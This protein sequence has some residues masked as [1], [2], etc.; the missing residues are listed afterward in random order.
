MVRKHRSRPRWRPLEHVGK[1]RGRIDER[2]QAVGPEHFG[3]VCI[4]PHKGSSVWMLADFYGKVLIEPTPV[5]HRQAELRAAMEQLR[6]TCIDRGIKDT[7]V[8]AERTGQYHLPVRRAFEAGGHEVRIIHPYAT[9]QYRQAADPGDKTDATDLA[10]MHR[11]AVNGFGLTEQSLPTVYRHLQL[12]IRHRRDWVY[13]T[14]ALRTQIREHLGVAMPGY[15]DLNDKFFESDTMLTLARRFDSADAILRAGVDG[16]ADALREAKVQCQRRTLERIV[17]WAGNA[18]PADPDPLLQQQI[19]TA[20]DDD[21]AAKTLQI[22]RL[23]GQ[24]ASL[25]VQTPYLLLLAIPGINVVSAADL[26][27]E[28][29]PIGH[30]ANAN[31]I[32]GRAGL[33]PA[34]AQSNFTDHPDGALR[35]QSNRRLRAVLTQ[36]ADNLV[37]C[38]QHFRSKA[39]AWQIADKDVRAI[40]VRVAKS[41]SRLAYAIVAGGT[42]FRHPAL[43]QRHYVLDKLLAFYQEHDTPM[44][45]RREDLLAAVRWIPEAERDAEAEPLNEQLQ[46]LRASRRRS[47]P[48]LLGDIL[49]LVLEKLGVG[50][51]QSGK[52]EEP[53]PG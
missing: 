20:L 12:L 46:K 49:P 5:S 26:A 52:S 2:V 41:F 21:R 24:S 13:K 14:T 28:L 48:V 1:P 34:R 35:R 15:A 16:L 45:Q 23:E 29:G 42:W 6:K 18:A 11:A 19:W 53:N 25:L 17:A 44:T 32:T 22:R 37:C 39:L 47:G 33:C 10:A 31:A 7:I 43:Q 38:N 36:I 40:R 51:V 3:I 50:S 4:D 9:K 27:G 30:Y 8:V